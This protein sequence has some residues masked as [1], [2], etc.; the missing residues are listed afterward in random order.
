MA[1]VPI[2]HKGRAFICSVHL[3]DTVPAGHFS[4]WAVKA[5]MRQKGDN[6]NTGLVADL[7]VAWIDP[8]TNRQLSFYCSNTDDWPEGLVSIEAL[9]SN[10]AGEQ[11]RSSAI[12]FNIQ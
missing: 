2:F 9:F 5:E 6:T 12:E 1:D 7:D 8:G 11:L 4:E 3:P 10:T